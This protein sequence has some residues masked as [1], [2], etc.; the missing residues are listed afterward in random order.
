MS[1]KKKVGILTNGCRRAR[2]KNQ[3]KREKKRSQYAKIN[4]KSKEKTR[5]KFCPKFWL[6]AFLEF[7][8]GMIKIF[9]IYKLDE[10]TFF[11]CNTSSTAM[12]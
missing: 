1:G 8:P 3:A 11:R 10:I 9:K 12:N 7:C 4:S 2:A 5:Q 6:L